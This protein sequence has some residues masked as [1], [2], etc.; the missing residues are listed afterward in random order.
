MYKLILVDS[1]GNTFLKI[2]PD[3]Q[4][5]NRVLLRQADSG[6]AAFDTLSS[7]TYDLALV[8]EQ[9]TDMT[10]IEFVR[11]LVARYPFVNCA[12]VSSM[13]DADFHEATEGLGILSK[14]P[15]KPDATHVAE[16]MRKLES[17]VTH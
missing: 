7:G 8:S 9:L 12:L 6:M 3:L 17:I 5:D 11:Q 4:T 2:I 14:L 16:L 15:S 13:Q 10:G 1:T